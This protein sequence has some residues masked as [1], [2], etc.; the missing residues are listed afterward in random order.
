MAFGN[1]DTYSIDK[2]REIGIKR[3]QSD[4][5]V[6]CWFTSTGKMMPRLIKAKMP[7]ESILTLNNISV[8]ECEDKL[9]CGIHTKKFICNVE[10][11]NRIETIELHFNKSDCIWKMITQR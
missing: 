7:D 5:A 9:Y 8:R 6:D 4:I 10:Y 3:N 1:Q 11:D 2:S